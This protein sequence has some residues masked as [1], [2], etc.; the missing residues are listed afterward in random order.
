M[1]DQLTVRNPVEV[2]LVIDVIEFSIHD[3][4][5]ISYVE[6]DDTDS[7]PDLNGSDPSDGFDDCLCLFCLSHFHFRFMGCSLDYIF[8]HFRGRGHEC[9]WAER[10]AVRRRK[11]ICQS[12]CQ[13]GFDHPSLWRSS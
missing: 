10:P 6:S 1:L 7:V 2:L 9:G 11:C 12:Q 5:H 4:V 13:H 8:S 3:C